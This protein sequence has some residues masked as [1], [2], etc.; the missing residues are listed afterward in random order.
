M[1]S[2]CDAADVVVND[3]YGSGCSSSIAAALAVIDPRCELLVLMLGD[4]PGV[5]SSTVA[6]LRG[7]T[8]RCPAGRVP[9]PGRSRAPD[10]VRSQL[11]RAELADL[12]G[13]GGVWRMLDR[14]AADA[15]EV[16]I[17]GRVPRR[18]HR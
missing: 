6:A 2:T 11:L 3:A 15:V 17:A 18:R 14:R 5:T 16:P 9:L 1:P 12:H 7:R 10:R 4:Q 13:D 8:R